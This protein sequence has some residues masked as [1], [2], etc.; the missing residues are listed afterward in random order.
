MWNVCSSPG[1][2]PEVTS[3]AYDSIAPCI[4][5]ERFRYFFANLG[6]NLSNSPSMS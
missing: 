6:V 5:A 2:A 4:S 3:F 1:N